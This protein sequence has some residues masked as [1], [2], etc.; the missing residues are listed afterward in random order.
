M[1][2]WLVK[3][4]LYKLLVLSVCTEQVTN[5]YSCGPVTQYEEHITNLMTNKKFYVQSGAGIVADSDPESEW[6]ECIQKSKVFLDAVE[7]IS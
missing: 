4:L 6:K 1:E 2:V 7:M 3:Y 5:R